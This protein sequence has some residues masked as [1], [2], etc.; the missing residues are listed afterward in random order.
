MGSAERRKYGDYSPPQ[1]LVTGERL[2]PV[3]F[4]PLAFD[5]LG[6]WGPAAV[7]ALRRWAKRRLARPDALR[8]IRRTGLYARVLARWRASGA[9][10]LQR[11]NFETYASCVGLDGAVDGEERPIGLTR[12][13]SF[14]TDCATLEA[15]A[16][17]RRPS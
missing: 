4:V 13:V 9:C 17:R 16:W 3:S 10:A 6:R 11:G 14:L 12:Y 7:D 1:N 2:A 15:G 5:T 8:S